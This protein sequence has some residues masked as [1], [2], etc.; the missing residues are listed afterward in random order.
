MIMPKFVLLFVGIIATITV[1]AGAFIPAAASE[2]DKD[3]LK[4][5]TATCKAEVQERARYEEISWYGRHKLVKDCIKDLMNR[6]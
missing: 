4:Q 3:A 5:A 2:A 1:C 6:H